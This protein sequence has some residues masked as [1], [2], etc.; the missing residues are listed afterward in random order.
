MIILHLK[1]KSFS[2]AIRVRV[3]FCNIIVKID[4]ASKCEEIYGDGHVLHYSDFFM[5]RQTT[6]RILEKKIDHRRSVY[7]AF[8]VLRD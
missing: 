3:F 6:V 8:T 7:V 4:E 1:S 5:F 2:I